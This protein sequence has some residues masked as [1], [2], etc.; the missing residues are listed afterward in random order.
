MY[1]ARVLLFLT[2][3]LCSC[4]AQSNRETAFDK[5]KLDELF[6]LIEEKNKGMGSISIFRNGEEV[7]QRSIGYVDVKDGIRATG[8]TKYRIGSISK[9]FTAAIIMQLVEENKLSLST[10][11]SSYFPALPNADRITVEHLLRHRSGLYNFTNAQDYPAWMEEPKARAELLELF[12]KN[13]TVFEPGAK[14]EYSN[15]NFVLLSYIAEE[16]DHKDFPEILADRITKPLNLQ[17]TRYG[18]PINPE[19]GEARS[20]TY[21]GQWQEGTETDMSIPEGAGAVIASPK[22]LNTFYHA[23]FSGKVVSK[24]SL[25]EMKTLVDRAGMGL[26]Q[27]PF[28]DRRGFGHTGGIDGF[29]SMAVYF[30][31]DDVSI[32]YTANGAGMAINDIMIGALSIYFGRDYAIP[33]FPPALVVSSEALDV[34]LGTYSSPDF[35]LKITI[36]KKDSILMGQGSGQPAF[37]LEA[38]EPD[39]FRFDAAG[40]KLEFVPKEDKMILLQGGGRHVLTRE[41]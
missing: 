32:T 21:A 18:G 23:L 16:I 11:L 26:F 34:Y 5:T 38:Y 39:K 33:E 36:T 8:N 6:S 12:L 22:D 13:G 41:P 9:T 2:L 24:S 17:N 27:V 1:P 37:P 25:D 14:M 4:F 15:T 3:V 30:P 20:Y 40:V 28:H 7:Y 31:D 19:K 10:K 29:Q 35:P